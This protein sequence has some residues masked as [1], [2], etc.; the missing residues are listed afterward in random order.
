MHVG[1]ACAKWLTR[2]DVAFGHGV[3]PVRDWPPLTGGAFAGAS[4]VVDGLA[5]AVVGVVAAVAAVVVVAADDDFLLLPVDVA[6]SRAM[7]PT[8]RTTARPPPIA[9]LRLERRLAWAWA[10]AAFAAALARWRWRLSV[11]TG[12]HGTGALRPPVSRAGV[13]RAAGTLPQC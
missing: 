3:A 4:A 8:I 2:G 7:T 10:A 5:G 12:G 1:G 13:H 9:R 11:G 6:M